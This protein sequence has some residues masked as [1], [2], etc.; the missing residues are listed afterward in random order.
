[1]QDRAVLGRHVG[2]I[3]DVL[4][5]HRQAVQ[6][7]QRPALGAEFV[8][9]VRL[10]QRQLG[11]EISPGFD[12][13]VILLNPVQAGLDDLARG[14]LALAQ[15]RQ[16]RGR[17]RE[18]CLRHNPYPNFCGNRYSGSQRA[19]PGKLYISTMARMT[20]ARYGMMP[21]KMSINWICGGATPF[22]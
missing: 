4:D 12:I 2:G 17:G 8:R 1:M 13:F 14:Y 18:D 6:R 7:A 10:F 20:M 5:A 15:R 16:R 21:R 3:Q 22:R 19:I 9:T 11:I